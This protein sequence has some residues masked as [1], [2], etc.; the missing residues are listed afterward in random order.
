MI[1]AIKKSGAVRLT[2]R[3]GLEGWQGQAAGVEGRMPAEEAEVIAQAF[4]SLARMDPDFS[5]K[6]EPVPDGKRR[7][8]SACALAEVAGA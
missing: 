8:V 1:R 6:A 4:S 5:A 7:H 2:L 3:I